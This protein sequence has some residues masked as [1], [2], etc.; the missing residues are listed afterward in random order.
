[1]SVSEIPL[2][3]D[4]QQFAITIA[5]VNYRMRLVWREHSWT[6][7]LLNA[8]KTPVALSLSLIAGSDLLEQYAYLNLGF[9]LYV[10]SDVQER[11]NPTKNDLGLLSHLYIV[12]E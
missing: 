8:D 1:M 10:G 3:A 7:D 12:T 9:S 4:N 11:E 2:S 5:G 6:L